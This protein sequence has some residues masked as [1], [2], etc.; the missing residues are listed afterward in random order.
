MRRIPFGLLL[1]LTA[2]A[3]FAQAPYNADTT[4]RK[5]VRDYPDIRIASAEAPAPVQVRKDLEYARRGDLS[6]GLDLYL[7]GPGGKPAPLVILVHGGGW[8][9]G[10]RTNMAPLAARLAARGYAAATVSYRLSG[11]ARYP[12]A[13]EDVQ[14]AVR[15]LRKGAGS[16]GIDPSRVAIAGGSAGGQIAALVGMLEPQAIRAVVN[17]DGLSDFTS[18][19]A[20]RHEDDPN[21]NP[22]AAGA[23]FG[24]RYAEKEALWREASP[25]N[26]VGKNSP[27]VLFITSGVPRFSVGREA[28]AAKLATHGVHSDT[29][30][31]A[32]TPH[33][34]WLFDPW[35]SPTVDVMA[36]FLERVLGP[37]PARAPWSPD[38]GDGR[39]RNPIL[40]ADYSD[41]DAIRVGDTYYMVSSSFA[42]A[43]GLPLLVS[44]D[45]VNWE[46]QGHALPS[47]VPGAQFAAPQHGKGVWAPSL[48][49]HDGKF[50]IFYPD[51][52]NGIYVT[53]AK[54][55]K[56]PWSTPHLLLPGKGIIDPAPLWDEDG[57]AY[58]IHAWAKSRAGFN[59]VLTLRK[60][61]PDGRSLLDSEGKV[62]IDGDKL[63]GYRTL[64]GPKLYKENGYYYVFAPAGGVEHGWQS[65]FRSRS[66]EGPYES[67]IVMEQGATSINGPHQGAWVRTPQGSDW[68]FHFQDKRAYGRV[69]HLQP[70]RWNDGWPL[71]G[72]PSSKPGVGQPV[73]EHAK[74]LAGSFAQQ[75]PATSDEFDGRTLG[76]QWQW[77]ANPD[78]RWYALDARAGQLRLFAQ[79]EVP[80]RS[81]PSV[82]TQKFPAPA[83]GVTAKV[84][85]RAQHDGDQVGL[86]TMGLASHWFGLRRVAG[87]PR[88]VLVCC[89][90]DGKCVEELGAEL[91][92]F[93]A[94]LRMHVTAGA[95][96]AF[97]Y[98]ADGLRY[99][100]LGAPFDATMGRWVGTQV[101]M[102]ATG[103]AG[104]YADVDYLRITP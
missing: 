47:L 101:G 48:R 15:W 76:P 82:L 18:E 58:L 28:M 52:D 77:A 8:G 73:T 83:F 14:E 43:P 92:G 20:R 103:A 102:F 78:S 55:F 87:K 13:I 24:G 93:V 97:W 29:V 64:E 61:A 27:P 1:A 90:Q 68:F 17:I 12:A 10:E 2:A 95:R 45:M 53:T 30:A 54:D 51:P 7:P 69:V 70:M 75:V 50:W 26:H 79:P 21:K 84:D 31:L 104:S 91:P 34:F 36:A 37:V 6:L 85:L 74:P 88:M 5:L 59:N 40:H 25:I 65:V 38:L 39:Y 44:K 63:P 89:A 86:G 19:E 72:E 42:N 9:S 56:G 100:Q 62:V 46:L 23:W 60:M 80:V 33:S 49:H 3:A 11:Q 81:L 41:P 16:H 71:I 32:G 99:T 22:S 4:Y 57:K 66:I 94:H 67:R 96:V 98:S 35:V